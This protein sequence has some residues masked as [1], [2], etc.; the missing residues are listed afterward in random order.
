MT[1]STRTFVSCRRRTLLAVWIAPLACFAPVGC[2]GGIAAVPVSGRVTIDGKPLEHVAVGF[3]P[4]DGQGAD[5]PGSTGA[6]DAEGRFSLKTAGSHAVAGAVVG[7]HRVTLLDTGNLNGYNPYT[8]RN[9]T[10]RQIAAKMA[11]FRHR[12]PPE[13][14]DGSL[15]FEVPPDGT[16]EANFD[17][18]SSR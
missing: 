15:T 5:K 2:G 1:I 9:L 12:L 11:Q 8:D 13:A 14:R 16:Y 4:I 3:V 18:Q 10:S 7:K 17:L 6:T